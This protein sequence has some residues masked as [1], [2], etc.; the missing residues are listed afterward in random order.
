MKIFWLF[1][2]VLF[3]VTTSA[4]KDTITFKNKDV[5][6]GE[7]K[8]LNNN[9]LTF[10]TSYSDKDFAIEFGQV[11]SLILYNK[12]SVVLSNGLRLYGYVKSET[13]NKATITQENNVA[14]E[15]SLSEIVVLRKIDD[16]F[17]K[18]FKGSFDFGYN[19]T[20]TNNSEQFTFAGTVNY[21]S[22]RWIHRATYNQLFTSQDDVEDIKRTDW[23]F[24]TKRYLKR[25]WFLNAN[26]S[27]LSNTSQSLN[28]RFVPSIAAGNYLVRNNR[29]YFLAGT[30]L[31][32]NIEK[33]VDASTDKTST[34]AMLIT[35]FNMF[36]FKDIDLYFSAVGYPS[37]SEKGRFRT[38]ANFRFKYNLPFDFYFKTELQV[39]FDNQ[40][41]VNSV[42]TDYVFSTGF[43]WELK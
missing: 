41:A 34:E 24:D 31:T 19:L 36:N 39:N 21:F 20:R 43:G 42:R 3:S 9:I 17:W 38:D 30:G 33:Y 27:F 15:V 29:L 16:G 26:F 40:P 10:K 12:Y 14:L 35:Q 1:F 37:L 4:Q 11:V 6:V 23:S 18:H 2:F 5:I 8:Q 22:E 32:Y 13:P 25:K 28:G 7:L